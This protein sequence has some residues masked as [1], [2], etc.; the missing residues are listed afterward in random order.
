M[1]NRYAY[2]NMKY[3][4]SSYLSHEWGNLGPKFTLTHLAIDLIQY[5]ASHDIHPNF[6][7]SPN[8]SMSFGLLTSLSG[9]KPSLCFSWLK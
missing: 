7:K 5:D 1:N 8:S 3:N 4:K 2:L 6:A 9:S